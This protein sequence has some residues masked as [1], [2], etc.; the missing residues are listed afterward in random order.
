MNSGNFVPSEGTDEEKVLQQLEEIVRGIAIL[1]KEGRILP[2][3]MLVYSTLDIWASLIR[4]NSTQDNQRSDFIMWVTEYML[5]HP[6]ISL[7]AVDLYAARCGMLHALSPT[8]NLSRE[9]KAKEIVYTKNGELALQ[10]SNSLR[11]QG[12]DGTHA[13]VAVPALL[14]ALMRAGGKFMQALAHDA[15]L[16]QRFV[17]NGRYVFRIE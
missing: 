3:L 17:A 12:K 16:S 8:S 1:C 14:D 10:A 11:K 15:V 2:A 6:E 7:S 9:G 4:K 13:A 5:P